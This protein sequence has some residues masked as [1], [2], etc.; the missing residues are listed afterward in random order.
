MDD[1]ARKRWQ[2]AL[3]ANHMRNAI[4]GLES[5]QR[6]TVGDCLQ[7]KSEPDI[8]IRGGGVHVRRPC[9]RQTYTCQYN[10]ALMNFIYM[11]FLYDSISGRMN[12]A[13]E[14]LVESK[15]TK[16]KISVCMSIIATLQTGILSEPL[17]FRAHGHARALARSQNTCA[18]AVSGLYS[19]FHN[20]DTDKEAKA[21]G[22]E[23]VSF[24]FC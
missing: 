5:Q 14:T 15:M 6:K 2:N 20:G 13:E 8:Q 11:R 7:N 9:D 4:D 10:D 22:E 23:Y 18:I 17:R 19:F 16:D 24:C 1:A 12:G 21:Q 3:K